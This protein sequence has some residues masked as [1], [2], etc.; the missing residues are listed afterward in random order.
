MRTSP[1][2]SLVTDFRKSEGKVWW[3]KHMCVREYVFDVIK[4]FLASF[5]P[6]EQH[7][8]FGEIANLLK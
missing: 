1:S 8:L 4:G 2:P 7:V 6:N 5:T 3:H